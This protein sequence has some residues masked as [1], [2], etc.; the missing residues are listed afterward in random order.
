MPRAGFFALLMGVVVTVIACQKKDDEPQVL[1]QIGAETL[2]RNYDVAERFAGQSVRVR[3][4]PDTYAAAGREIHVPGTVPNT[5]PILIFRFEP[6]ETV[7]GAG[8]CEIT[9]KCGRPVRDGVWR[10][11]RC[12]YTLIISGCRVKP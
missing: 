8:G 11:L 7:P 10:T 2:T 4:Q 5:P 6:G 1:Y 3:L 9:G 12:D